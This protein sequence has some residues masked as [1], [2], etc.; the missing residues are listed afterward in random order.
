[1]RIVDHVLVEHGIR[2]A[3]DERRQLFKLF[4]RLEIV[5]VDL[6]ASC[7]EEHGINLSLALAFD[8]DVLTVECF[9]EHFAH[10]LVFAEERSEA[11]AAGNATA[12]AIGRVER[13]LCNLFKLALQ[14]EEL[15]QQVHILRILNNLGHKAEAHE[16][17]G[18]S[19]AHL[20]LFG[21]AFQSYLLIFLHEVVIETSLVAFL[22][23]NRL[24]AK[25][26]EEP[27]E[28]VHNPSDLSQLFG[29]APGAFA[30][31]TLHILSHLQVLVHLNEQI[32]RL[33]QFL[34]QMALLFVFA[35][36]YRDFFQVS[37]ALSIVLV[38]GTYASARIL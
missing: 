10:L 7:W 6:L 18:V 9:R 32:A 14:F 36:G 38:R 25:V 28:P 8:P 21:V 34:N 35:V 24:K 12:E 22:V 33:A 20:F 27:N 15:L 13:L 2:V 23:I 17:V 31:T 1:M 29:A 11:T 26:L 4:V 30:E 37:D 3:N 16:S 19:S 5:F